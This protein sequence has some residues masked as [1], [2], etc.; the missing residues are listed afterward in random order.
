MH[1]L[2]M[3]PYNTRQEE[4]REDPWKMLMV[5]FM[6]NQTSHTQVDQIRH[7]FFDRFPNAESI[8]LAEDKEISKLIKS[9]GFYNKRT[10]A[11]KEFCHQWINE[12]R[13]HG[14]VYLPLSTLEKMKGVGKYALDSWKIFQLYQYDTKAEDHVLNW[15]L[16]WAQAEMERQ[17]RESSEFKPML[18]Y[19]LHYKDERLSEN[20]WNVCGDYACCVMA[21]TQ[22]EAIEKVKAIASNQRGHKYIKIMG[23]GHAKAEWVDEESPLVTD[24]SE[25]TAQVTALFNRIQSKSISANDIYNNKKSKN[26]VI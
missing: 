23:F 16:D 9:L 1:K 21:R 24:E 12:T 2:P 8:V 3:S 14:G 5:C 19:Y 6:L 25:Y 11:W 4:Y 7:E 26:Q 13:Y 17:K 22:L 20:N 18:V 15:Y 10:K